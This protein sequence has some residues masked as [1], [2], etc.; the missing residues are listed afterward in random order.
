MGYLIQTKRSK[1]FNEFTEDKQKEFFSITPK[2]VLHAIDSL[3]FSVS[4]EDD[5]KERE[6]ENIEKFLYILNSYKNLEHDDELYY[7]YE[8]ELLYKDISFGFYRHCISRNKMF[9]I[10]ICNKL[11]NNNT[12]RIVV[13]IRSN[14]LWLYGATDSIKYIYNVLLSIFSD[15]NLNIK[16]IIENRID[17]CY[18]TNSLQNFDSYFSDDYIKNNLE[19]MFKIGSKVFKK[20]NNN[21]NIEYL[22]LGNRKSNN[23]FF[24]TYNKTSEVVEMAYKDFFIDVWLAYGLISKYDHYI[25][26]FCYE[27]GSLNKQYEARLRFYIKYGSDNYL[28]EKCKNVL[29][30]DSLTI[31]QL[32]KFSK[33]IC[34]DVTKVQNFEFQTMRKFYYNSDS[35]IDM[36]PIINECDPKLLRLQQILDNRKIFLDYL[37]SKTVNFKDTK[38]E[39]TS[40]F[41][42]RIQT[43]KL[44]STL[45][46]TYKRKYDNNKNINLVLNKLKSNLAT[47]S[48]YKGNDETDIISDICNLINVLNDNDMH[49]IERYSV[50]KNKKAKAQKSINTLKPLAID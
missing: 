28:I 47:Y 8:K 42:K 38:S 16:S 4:L 24:R 17:F 30:N 27:N 41:W 31:E 15:Y 45:Q 11:P 44:D 25:L 39:N 20:D 49:E 40:D 46:I 43:C 26:T 9:D 14:M 48:I 3:Y 19:T 35:L 23:L 6:N 21:L 18:H 32:R 5:I 10:F 33:G 22:S 34:P 36:L 2:K 37:T 29:S 1:I 50:L 12:P 7:D 13:Q